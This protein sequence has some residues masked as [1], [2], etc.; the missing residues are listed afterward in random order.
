MNGKRAATWPLIL[1]L[2][3]FPYWCS[4]RRLNE[5]V[6]QMSLQVRHEQHLFIHKWHRRQKHSPG[7]VHPLLNDLFRRQSST[8]DP[9]KV[10]LKWNAGFQEKEF[11]DAVFGRCCFKPRTLSSC[12]ARWCVANIRI[13]R[14][15]QSVESR[16]LRRTVSSCGGDTRK[17]YFYPSKTVFGR[18]VTLP[19][20]P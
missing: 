15:E 13:P 12:R 18:V 4:H 14:R 11:I 6:Q 20:A 19:R 5:A 8:D 7:E 1:T 10:R 16:K 17:M 3:E 9:N 2:G